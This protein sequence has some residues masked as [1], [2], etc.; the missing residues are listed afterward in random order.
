L[1]TELFLPQNSYV[2]ILTSSIREHNCIWRS[3]F[4]EVIKIK[5]GFSSGSAGKESTCNA[6]DTG[7]VVSIP[8]RRKWQLTPVFLSAESQGQRTW[9]A[10]VRGVAKSR[11]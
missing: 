7:D 11:T 6:G 2:N 1:R 3:T 10:T 5:Q 9:L 8:W 4:K